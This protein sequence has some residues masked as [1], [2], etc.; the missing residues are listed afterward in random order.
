MNIK[1]LRL[2]DEEILPILDGFCLTNPPTVDHVDHAI[3]DAA[4]EKVL[5]QKVRCTTCAGQGEY[6]IMERPEPG[7]ARF[8]SRCEGT[9]RLTV[10]QLLERATEGGS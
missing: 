2:T 5:A 10:R 4:T 7:F 1:Q 8:C 3:A 9:G 6:Q